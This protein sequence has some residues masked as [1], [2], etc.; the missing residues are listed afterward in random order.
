MKKIIIF[1][2]LILALL[3]ISGCD[4]QINLSN[5]ATQQPNQQTEPPI[6]ATEPPVQVTEPP[7]QPA[8]Q[9]NVTCNL[10][11][12][13]LDPAL[14][15][16]YSCQT[17]A[18]SNSSEMPSFGIYPEYTE[19]SISGYPLSGKFFE[20]HIDVFPVSRFNELLPDVV[21]AR[22]A[23]LQAFISSGIPAAGELPLLPVFN[24]AQTF[25]SQVAV[26]PFQNGQGVRFLTLYAQYFAPINNTDLFYT[27]QGLTADGQYWIS[28][29]LPINNAILPA[30][31]MTLPSG[32]TMDTFSNNYSNYIGDITAQL[33][34]QSADSFI[35][36]ITML[37]ALINSI[38]IQP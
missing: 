35:P 33:N 20:P 38:T 16:S 15:S 22:V 14:G 3:F 4:I 9:T 5:P 28:A 23:A 24:A 8:V 1:L 34:A 37:D 32:Q 17:I 25:S 18:E 26:I 2:L 13:Y 29:V 31:S 36:T 21:P 19:I 27:F 12:F 30:D 11:S 10:L 6:Q 7:A